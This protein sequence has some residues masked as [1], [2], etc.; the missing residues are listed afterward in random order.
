MEPKNSSLILTY[1][2]GVDSL[3]EQLQTGEMETCFGNKPWISLFFFLSSACFVSLTRVRAEQQLDVKHRRSCTA[4]ND[5]ELIRSR[6]FRGGL[7][8]SVIAG[9]RRDWPRCHGSSDG[10][11]I[12]PPAHWLGDGTRSVAHL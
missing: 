4:N 8:P 1:I 10:M 5:D 3:V 11:K 9:G 2:G 12:L 6:C 7:S